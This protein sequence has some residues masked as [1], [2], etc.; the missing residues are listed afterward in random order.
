[1]ELLRFTILSSLMASL[2]LTACTPQPKQE[3][4]DHP[5]SIKVTTRQISQ[6]SGPQQL[7]YTA[8][9]EAE[10][11]ARVGFAVPGVIKTVSVQE[12]DFVRQG[13][14]L[15][16]IDATEYEN[17]LAIA[18]AG[19]QQAEDLYGR[20]NELYQKGSLPAKDYMEIKT[21]L[22]QAKASKRINAKHIADSKLYAPISGIITEKLVERGST[23]GPGIAAFTI[24]KTDRVYARV[25][26]PEAEIGSLRKG[27]PASVYVPTIGDT[28]KGTINII[29]PQADASSKTYSVKIAIANPSQRLLPGMMA[30]VTLQAGKA[31][32][33]IL[34]PATAIVRDEDEITYVYVVG[35]NRKAIRRRIAVGDMTGSDQLAVL[36]GLSAGEAIVV[37]GQSHLHDGSLVSL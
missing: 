26:V 5:K 9:I 3:A 6:T 18:D 12:G 33:L 4:E 36:S 28:L 32:S 16:T 20:L 15:A 14:L 21:K 25:T 23:A 35:Q 24:I 22:A 11:T 7:A 1:M 19:M 31:Q 17:A 13:Q 8:S 30:T 34:I 37:E 2:C 29:N 10:N 27:M